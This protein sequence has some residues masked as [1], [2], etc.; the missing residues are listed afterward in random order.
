MS[1]LEDTGTNASVQ[2]YLGELAGATGSSPA[3]RV[4]RNLLARSV[5]RL[6]LLC[7]TLL[8]QSYPRL[9]RPPLNLQNDEL[10]SSVVERLIKALEKSRPTLVRQ[11]FAMASQHIRWEL[12]DLARRLDREG[13]Q[14]EDLDSLAVAPDSSGSQLSQN[15]HRI[16]QAI[17]DLP[18]ME[19][20]VFS[21]IRIQGMTKAEAAQIMDISSKT[22]Q[23]R[24][25]HGIFLL[26]QAL[27]DLDPGGQSCEE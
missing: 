1:P 19:K 9:M 25:N 13:R 2:R 20:E 22:I 26:T 21:L 16:L 5:G 8:H 6:R 23:R 4:I 10:L 17:E 12:N 18:E 15:A 7:S 27:T 3:E 14:L 24:L 11:Y